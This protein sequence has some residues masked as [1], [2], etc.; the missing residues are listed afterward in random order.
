MDFTP[1]TSLGAVVAYISKYCSKAEIKSEIYGEILS[2][3]LHHLNDDVSAK[4]VF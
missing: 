1:I 3:V 4:V 2:S